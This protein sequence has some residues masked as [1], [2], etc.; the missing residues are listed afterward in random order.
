[1]T[2]RLTFQEA[3]SLLSLP[4]RSEDDVKGMR[5][6]MS[7][8]AAWLPGSDLKASEE[9]S[10]VVKNSI[11]N[12]NAFGGHVYCQAGMAAAQAMRESSYIQRGD[13]S[14]YGIHTMHG[15]WSEIG[16]TDRPFV[17]EVTP[18]SVSPLFIN[19]LVTARQPLS[20]S[21]TG[22]GDYYTPADIEVSMG[23][24]CF[25]S[26]VSFRPP[27]KTYYKHQEPSVQSRFATILSSRSPMEW[28]PAPP[29]DIDFYTQNT[30]RSLV[31]SFPALEMRKVDM[32]SFNNGRPLHERRELILY[33]LLAPL[34]PD[35]PAAHVMVHAYE[36]DRNGI[37][38]VVNHIG[39]GHDFGRVASLSNSIVVHTNPADA[40]M[41]NGGW[42]VQEVLIGRSDAGRGMLHSKIWDPKG[43]HVAT[44]YQ[45]GILRNK[46]ARRQLT[47]VQKL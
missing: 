33:R 46:G 39:W 7:V 23:K 31:G 28:I 21:T 22:S 8:R 19:L 47:A 15:Y 11:V 37:L 24:I 45:D 30:P 16:S 43:Q 27:E 32:R 14:Q 4:S 36:A 5:R 9:V 35:E 25:S 20:P 13:L 29:L 26:L 40:I 34:P 41:Q 18:L 17:Y 38:M 1:M 44:C 42:W 12:R 6:F 10:V 2:V 3:M